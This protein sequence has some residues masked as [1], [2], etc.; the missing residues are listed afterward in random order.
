MVFGVVQ[1]DIGLLAAAVI[2]AVTRSYMQPSRQG[3]IIPVQVFSHHIHL[4]PHQH[5]RSTGLD[6]LVGSGID[7]LGPDSADQL[8]QSEEI[9]HS[10]VGE[11]CVIFKFWGLLSGCLS[12]LSYSLSKPNLL[13]QLGE[14]V[15]IFNSLQNIVQHVH[16]SFIASKIEFLVFIPMVSGTSWEN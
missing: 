8:I 2:R 1:L 16:L 15:I 10:P 6:S 3:L 13:P 14:G 12:N 4:Y 7:D 9:L 11:Q 5:K